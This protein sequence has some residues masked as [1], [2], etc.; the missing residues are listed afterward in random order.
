M[1][2]RR[3]DTSVS[4]AI[5]AEIFAAAAG[6]SETSCW[7]RSWISIVLHRTKT[8]ASHFH[9]QRGEFVTHN[10]SGFSG[11]RQPLCA[12]SR[13]GNV[14]LP[15]A[16]RLAA[17]PHLR[18]LRLR[19]PGFDDRNVVPARAAARPPHPRPAHPVRIR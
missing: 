1:A 8:S 13:F 14:S 18:V 4:S 17:L 10:A 9:P 11:T 7:V 16:A 3:T 6:V 12:G 15:D 19:D 2:T 5:R